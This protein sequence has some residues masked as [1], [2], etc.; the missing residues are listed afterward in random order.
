MSKTYADEQ[1][2]HG[3]LKN[4]LL[5]SIIAYWRNEFKFNL[6]LMGLESLLYGAFCSGWQY[7]NVDL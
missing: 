3:A 6:T 1:S 5:I 7:P 4:S 2:I